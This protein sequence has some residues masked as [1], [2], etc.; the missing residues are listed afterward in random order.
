MWRCDQYRLLLTEGGGDAAKRWSGAGRSRCAGHAR[1]LRGNASRLRCAGR[2]S[3]DDAA[4]GTP[5]TITPPVVTPSAVPSSSRRLLV[6]I[7]EVVRAVLNQ[8]VP[9]STPGGATPVVPEPAVIAAMKAARQSTEPEV[10]RRALA[11]LDCAVPDPLRGSDVIDPTLPLVAC[12]DDGGT[13]KF[14]LAPALLTSAHLADAVAGRREGDPGHSITLRLT[15]AGA[16]IWADF[17]RRHS[18]GRRAATL[19]DGAVLAAPLLGCA[20][21]SEAM[22]IP[23][24]YREGD[25]RRI[26]HQIMS[27]WPHHS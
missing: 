21:S 24:I 12:T 26:A 7:R 16:A 15:P 9:T 5:S 2:C 25:A 10:Q 6:E 27:R 22:L 4:D 23:R 17:C 1:R 13:E 3:I 20:V 19:V 14:L 18:G 8:A 11:E